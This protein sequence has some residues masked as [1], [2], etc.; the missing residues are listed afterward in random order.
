[1]FPV[2]M[3][4]I[5]LIKNTL[6]LVIK[7]FASRSNISDFCRNIAADANFVVSSK[8]SVLSGGSSTVV[9][10]LK[11]VDRFYSSP[12]TGHFPSSECLPSTNVVKDKA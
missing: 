11:C 12:F 7:A 8:Q 2:S 4:L 3:T 6:L 1:M 5:F 10:T 9:F